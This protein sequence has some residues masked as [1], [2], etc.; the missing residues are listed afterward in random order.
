[1]EYQIAEHFFFG[2]FMQ[3]SDWLGG[4][5]AAGLDMAVS[6]FCRAESHVNLFSFALVFG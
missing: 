3:H 1:M 2:C 4:A 6:P 5:I